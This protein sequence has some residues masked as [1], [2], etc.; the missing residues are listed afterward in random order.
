MLQSIKKQTMIP[1]L[2]ANAPIGMALLDG[3]G[4]TKGSNKRPEVAPITQHADISRSASIGPPRAVGK[5][6]LRTK[7]AGAVTTLDRLHQ[8][9]SFK[10]LFPRPTSLGF[11]AVLLNTAGGVTG[12]DQFSLSVHAAK[13]TTMTLTTQTCER[14]Y[15]AQPDQ[16]GKLRNHLNV[17]PG[18]RINWLPQ[19]T[20]LFNGSALDRRLNVDL[21]ADASLLMVE[22]LIFGRPAMGEVLR[23]LRIR[24]RIEIRREGR[25]LFMDAMTLTGDVQAHLADPFVAGGAGAMALVVM[26][27]ANAE[28]HLPTLRA[29]LPDTGGASLIGKD[30]LVMR[31]LAEDGFA[32]RTIL[33]PILKCLNQGDFPRCW[34]I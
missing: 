10:C 14:A 25:P 9:G 7:R 20:I 3:E 23:N 30:V 1:N 33:L 24:D 4:K 15:K 29:A 8:S 21:A 27:A 5:L 2:I 19:E 34:M 28:S 22:P 31:V 6:R 13:G 26:V 12:G 32:L 17:G 18:A 16:T 11:E